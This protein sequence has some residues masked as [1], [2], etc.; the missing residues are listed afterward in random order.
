MMGP[1]SH[2]EER[3]AYNEQNI[4]EFRAGGGKIASFGD[5]PVLLLHTTG[6]RSGLRR[7]SP[8]MYLQ[9]EDDP[10]RV[11]VFA[12]AAG[13]ERDPAWFVNLAAQPEG[14]TVEIGSEVLQADAEVLQEPRRGEIYAIQAS[15]Y[16]AFAR[17]GEKTSRVIP[18][19]A[20][21]LR[22]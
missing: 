8:M 5:D 12:S 14:L 21:D 17:F 22:R 11:Y 20:L 6:A 19:V 9:D 16:P 4:A 7:V 18:V 3:L 15:R 13:Q 2:S 1:M 10:N